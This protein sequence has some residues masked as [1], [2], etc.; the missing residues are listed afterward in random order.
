MQYTTSILLVLSFFLPEKPQWLHS[1]H[2]GSNY[3]PFVPYESQARGLPLEAVTNESLRSLNH[4]VHDETSVLQ[5]G[6][7]P[8]CFI[9]GEK[10]SVFCVQ[11]EH[12]A[13]HQGIQL[14]HL[15]PPTQLT[16]LGQITQVT[17]VNFDPRPPIKILVYIH[18]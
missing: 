16:Q 6:E 7:A 4:P 15:I 8:G 2:K 5:E 3:I 18:I 10:A 9:Q 13:E 1:R 12:L 17:Q 11:R 14:P